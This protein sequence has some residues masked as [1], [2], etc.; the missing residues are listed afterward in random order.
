[1]LCCV[2]V[3]VCVCVRASETVCRSFQEDADVLMLCVSQTECRSFCLCPL[4][5]PRVGRV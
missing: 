3:C 5:F 2:C 4:L 1:M